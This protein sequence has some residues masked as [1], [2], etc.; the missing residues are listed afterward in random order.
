MTQLYSTDS[1]EYLGSY[2]SD[3]ELEGSTRLVVQFEGA[4]P[5]AAPCVAYAL[6]DPDG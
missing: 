1:L 3:F 4:L 2:H 5:E 6:V